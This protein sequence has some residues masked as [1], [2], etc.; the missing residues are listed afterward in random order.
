MKLTLRRA[1][2]QRLLSAMIACSEW[3]AGALARKTSRMVRQHSALSGLSAGCSRARFL[4]VI[5]SRLNK[6]R[7]PRLTVDR[8][9]AESSTSLLP[10][11]HACGKFQPFQRQ[12]ADC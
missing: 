2:M 1:S 5:L 11:G 7:G 9:N 4:P 10:S 8:R 12:F 3:G 6:V